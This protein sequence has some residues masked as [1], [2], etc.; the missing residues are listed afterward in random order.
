MKNKSP[1]SPS[2]K[3]VVPDLNFIDVRAVMIVSFY[4]LVKVWNR[5]TLSINDLFSS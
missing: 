5:G 4:A 2:S 3:I 1:S